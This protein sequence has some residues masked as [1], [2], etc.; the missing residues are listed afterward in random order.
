MKPIV[1][2]TMGD[3]GGIGPEII[4]KSLREAGLNSSFI[5]LIGSEEV[6]N[7]TSQ[8]L[9]LPFKIHRVGT[10]DRLLLKENVVNFFDVT[11]EAGLLYQIVFEQSRPQSECFSIGKISK[12]NAALAYAC[13]K[14]AAEQGVKGF[15]QG[16]VTAPIQKT[17]MRL[18]DP[19]FSGHTDYLA[20]TVRIKNYAMMFY[21]ERFCVTL[22]T[23]HLPL[24]KVAASLNAEDLLNKMLLT[25]E[26]LKKKLGLK[27]PKIAVCAL[28]PHGNEFG[29]EE[30]K[31]IEPAVKEAQKRGLLIEGPLP[32]DQVFFD[33]FEGRFQAVI[34]MYH[35]QGLAPFKMIAFREGVNVTLGLPYVRT[36]PDHGTAF[37][38]AYQNQAFHSA[39]LNSIRLAQ[40]TAVSPLQPAS[41]SSSFLPETG[42]L[43]Q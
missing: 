26:F 29:I 3:P 25:D 28:N 10:F 32:G 21:H 39:F 35:D 40:K 20:E 2:L 36:S 11:E 15:I 27:Q 18:I 7:F 24:K 6:F 37:D 9:R 14:L 12:W 19:N 43:G 17:G 42:L 31:I 16:L 34:A 4:L 22:A 41:K 38:I 13:L 33:A 8:R 5:F 23:I 1:A 30:D